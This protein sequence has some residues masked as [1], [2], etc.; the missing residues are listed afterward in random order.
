MEHGAKEVIA[1][2][3]HGILSGKAVEVLNNSKLKKVVVTNTVP[4]AE[5]KAQC[6]RLETI[7]ISPTVSRSLYLCGSWLIPL[8]LLRRVGEH[9][10]ARACLSCSSMPQPTS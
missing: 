6:S 2:V 8:S 4:H 7:D 10:M 3:T 5:K 1:V 9:T